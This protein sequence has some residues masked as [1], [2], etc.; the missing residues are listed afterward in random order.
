V[1]L[2]H[3]QQ[4]LRPPRQVNPAISEAAELVILRAMSKEPADR[5]QTA[6]EMARALAQAAAAETHSKPAQLA[7]VAEEIA[8][9]KGAEEVTPEIRRQLQKQDRAA[10]RKRLLALAPWG[11]AGLLIIGLA[12]TLLISLNSASTSNNAAGQTATAITNLL[13]QL[14]SAQTAVAAGGSGLE[15]TLQYLQTSLAGLPVT[16]T[17]GAQAVSQ[18]AT[19]GAAKPGLTSSTP[20]PPQNTPAATSLP[21]TNTGAPLPTIKVPTVKPNLP[22]RLPKLPTRRPTLPVELPLP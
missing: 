16:G 3:I 4:T 8:G 5:Y 9:T 2:M 21:A 15:P 22:T 20:G 7:L 10:S 1:A 12:A 6:G 11:I 19:S 17:P 18:T 13:N 14:S